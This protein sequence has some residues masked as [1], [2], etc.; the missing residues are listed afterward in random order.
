[1]PASNVPPG[2]MAD[3]MLARLARWLRVLGFDTLYDAAVHDPSSC[4]C[5][6]SKGARC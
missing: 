2:L 6:T 1:M 5:R 3:A 4:A